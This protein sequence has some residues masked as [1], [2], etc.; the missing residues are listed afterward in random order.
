M[1][2]V[3]HDDSREEHRGE[4][5]RDG[6]EAEPRELQADRGQAPQ[7]ERGQEPGGER[8][9]RDDDRERDHGENR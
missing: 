2:G 7:R 4:R 9:E 3:E 6:D 1:V 8:P 5:E